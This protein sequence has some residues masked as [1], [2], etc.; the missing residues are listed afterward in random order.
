MFIIKNKIGEGTFSKVFLAKSTK[1]P[2]KEYALKFIIPTLKPSRIVSELRFLR[3]LGGDA[4][5]PSIF[6]CLYGNG[7]S[8]L[9]MPYFRH[10]LFVD[11]VKDL[12]ASEIQDYMRNLLIALQK[13]HSHG[14]IHRD[15]KPTNFLYNRCERKFL[16]VDFGLSQ[17]ESDLQREGKQIMAK[18][19]TVSDKKVLLDSTKA[20]TNTLIADQ[21]SKQLLIRK[22]ALNEV[23]KQVKQKR[24]KS[25]EQQF[26]KPSVFH[27]P[28]TPNGKLNKQKEYSF[29]TPT[30]TSQNENL[31]TPVKENG[32]QIIP[33][34]PPR[35]VVK[36]LNVESS[37]NV[38]MNDNSINRTPKS[39]PKNYQKSTKPS[40]QCYCHGKPQYCKRCCERGEL[41]APRAGTPGFRAPEV[42]L[43]YLHQT[44][45]I[46]MWS[47]GVIYA[48]LL[49]TRYPFFRNLD[50]LTSLAEIVSIFGAEKVLNTA[51]Q[52]GKCLL[53]SARNKP[54]CCLKT[55]CEKLRGNENF[56][57]DD[58]AY[59]LLGKLLDPNPSTRITAKEALQHRFF[60]VEL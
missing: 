1:D 38:K 51:N 28:S 26:Q 21:I 33:E 55:L 35:S 56:K 16:L 31:M 52:L 9:V 8:V 41:Q 54:P 40:E 20:T 15:I 2:S 12:S 29:K 60:S 11:Y 48:S 24:L 59:D 46:D 14:V 6:T 22:R 18:A 49:S 32:T 34:T 5:I 39:R 42:L 27:T 50:D 58:S 47:V 43:K 25:D 30:K 13:I 44:T 10:D 53:L 19:M 7:Y 36:T 45:A 57:I 17:N 37:A 23:D 4:N 3:D